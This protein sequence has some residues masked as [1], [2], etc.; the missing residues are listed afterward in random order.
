MSANLAENVKTCLNKLNVRKEM[1]GQ[2]V[3]QF[4]V[5]YRITGNTKPLL[6][7]WYEKSKEKV[8]LN[9]NMFLRKKIQPNLGVEVV[10]YVSLVINGGKV[11]NGSKIKH[12]SLNN[13]KLKIAGNLM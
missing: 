9:G 8:L 3:L 6:E 5:G 13:Q 2:M 1:R 7:I 10:K 4:Y 12:N 11:L